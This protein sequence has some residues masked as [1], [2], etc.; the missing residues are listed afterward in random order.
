MTFYSLNSA[1]I[2][3]MFSAPN[4]FIKFSRCCFTDLT[5]SAS[6]RTVLATLF[7]KL[8]S[9]EEEKVNF[10]CWNLKLSGNL[11]PLPQK[12]SSKIFKHVWLADVRLD[13]ISSY[14]IESSGRMLQ[15]TVKQFWLGTIGPTSLQSLT[16][17]QTKRKETESFLQ[18]STI[19]IIILLW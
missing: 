13:S 12:V 3:S 16:L 2:L 1:A 6:C 5:V 19:K 8:W 18:V 14:N 10:K 4:C 11:E 9:F 7:L 15:E 17:M